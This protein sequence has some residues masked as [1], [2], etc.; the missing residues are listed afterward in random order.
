MDWTDFENDLL[1]KHIH[2]IDNN[3]K[4]NIVLFGSC[5]MSTIGY[6]LNRLLNYEYNIHI[7]ISWLFTNKGIEKFDMNNINERISKLVSN[8][9]VF[10]YHMHINDYDVNASSLP[11][12]VNE[13]CLKLIV[14]NY[15]LD[16]TNTD[17]N[18]FYES[19]KMLNMHIECSSFP[20]FKFITDNYKDIIFFNTP[21]H[22]THYLL[23]LQ[24]EYI[25]NIIFNNKQTI[26]IGNYYD[27]LNRMYFKDFEYVTLPGKIIVN[28]EIS[29]ITG[30]R[31]DAEYFD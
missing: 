11:S 25:S 18:K 4:K 27:I 21:N 17:S 13:K 10:I 7:I 22:P 30:I 6:I 8:C 26:T 9:D 28:D 2:T 15:R 29:N 5:H 24:S 1:N 23:F 20:E 31:K 14:P 3:S 19:L 16:F 12:L